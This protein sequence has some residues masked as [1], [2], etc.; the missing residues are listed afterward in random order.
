M[1][2]IMFHFG[3]LAVSSYGIMLAIAF[4]TAL[5][6]ASR[7]GL[8]EGIPSEKVF[9]PGTFDLMVW[10]I[11]GGFAGARI[12]NIVS[13]WSVHFPIFNTT[14]IL[15]LV[16]RGGYSFYGGLIGGMVACFLFVRIHG[17]PLWR[18]TDILAPSIALGYA[19]GRIGCLLAGC[20]YGRPCSLPWAITFP[21]QCR[22]APSG[23]PLH[24]TQ[25]YESLLNLILYAILLWLYPRKK[26]DGQIFAIYLIGYSLLRLFVEIY[27]G[28]SPMEYFGGYAT[29]T[30]IASSVVFIAGLALIVLLPKSSDGQRLGTTYKAR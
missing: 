30:Q 13:D 27:R 11:V 7:R 28:D 23:I 20:C 3:H 10:L 19:I 12:W 16:W 1:H 29:K 17:L 6:T 15:R 26:F 24:P 18:M 22:I 5:W 9:N 21:N 25:V 2:P 14:E 4:L 8:R